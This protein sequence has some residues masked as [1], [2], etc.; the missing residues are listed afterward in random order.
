M[1]PIVALLLFAFAASAQDVY[2]VILSG[3]RIVDGTGNAW[4]LG[5][6]AIAGNRVAKITGAGLL[7]RAKAKERIDARG[8]VVTPGFVD[9][10]GA[11]GGPS[12]SKITQGVTTEIAGEGWTAAP[13]NDLTRAGTVSTGRRA[14]EENFDGMHG[15][16]L[17]LQAAE[18]RGSA[19]NFGSYVG[20]TTVRQYVKGMAAGKATPDEIHKMQELVSLAM[21]DG[22]FGIGSALIYPPATYVDTD[23]LAEITRPV[24][25]YRG[26]YISHIR[27]EADQFLEALDEAIEIGRRAGTPVEIYHLKAAG[28]R[29]WEKEAAA[30]RKIDD[31]RKGGQDVSACMYPYT[32]GATG[33]TSVLPPWTAQ[34]GKLLDNLA[35]PAIRERIKREMAQEKTDWENMGQLAGPENILIVGVKQPDNQK[36]AGKRLNEI[37]MMRNKDWRDAAMDLILTER[38]R[39]DTIYFLMSEDNI[40]LQLRQPWIKFGIDGRG[41]DPEEMKGV[42]THPRAYGTFPRVLGLY[43]RDEKVLPLED[44]IRKMTSAATRRLGIHDRG[45]LQEGLFADI[46][47]FNPDTI[48]DHATFEDPNQLST[49]VEYVFVNGVAVVKAGK[50]TGEKPGL[51][52]HGPGYRKRQIVP[53]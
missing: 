1:K 20:A 26:L 18:K 21:E 53:Q 33:L 48:T 45:L 40:K 41:V 24:A 10:Q 31:A 25:Q 8:L 16:D 52:L 36:Y 49:G 2:D 30:I 38:T 39:V 28:K 3:G 23:E 7:D 27:S 51:A 5:D 4:F 6:L 50:V 37:A 11:L 42:L 32:A 15:F 12:I 13:S 47:V 17:M 43:V 22:A 44:A 46:A 35:D 34:D 14:A 9:I 29:N 19:V